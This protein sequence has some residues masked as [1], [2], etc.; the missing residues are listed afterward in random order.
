MDTF[1]LPW[2]KLLVVVDEGGDL[3]TGQVKSMDDS[4]DV[5]ERGKHIA[6]IGGL[7]DWDTKQIDWE[8][9]TTLNERVYHTRFKLPVGCGTWAYI[10]DIPGVEGQQCQCYTLKVTIGG[11][12]DWDTDGIHKA[13]LGVLEGVRQAQV[14]AALEEAVND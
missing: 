2:S 6:I 8:Q 13:I 7:R 1:E 3:F 9:G 14:N 4:A 12:F 5:F 11:L 10:I